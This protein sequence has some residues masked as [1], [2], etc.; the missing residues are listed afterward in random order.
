MRI[1]IYIYL[2]RRNVAKY[3]QKKLESWNN[4]SF[5]KTNQIPPKPKTPFKSQK[6]KSKKKTLLSEDSSN[7]WCGVFALSEIAFLEGFFLVLAAKSMSIF[8]PFLFSKKLNYPPKIHILTNVKSSPP[9]E[10]MKNWW[11]CLCLDQK[12]NFKGCFWFWQHWICCY[13][14]QHC[15]RHI[16]IQSQTVF[17]DK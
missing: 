4:Q 14:L 8:S 13:F 9:Q 17:Y 6:F 2:L 7:L 12:M 3:V 5:K 16:C 15:V 1:H 11:W 10:N